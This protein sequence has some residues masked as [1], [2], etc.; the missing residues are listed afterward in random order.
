MSFGILYGL[1]WLTA[2]IAAEGPLVLIIDD[3]HWCDRASLRFITYLERRLEGLQVLVATATRNGRARAEAR[4]IGE[5]AQDPAAVSI[6]PDALTQE[7]VDTLVRERLGGTAERASRRPAERRTGGNPLLLQE[8]LKTLQAEHVTPDAAHVDL[9]RDIGPRAVSQTVLLRLRGCLTIR[10][11]SLGPWRCWAPAPGCRYRHLSELDDR[12]VA[13]ATRALISAEILRSEAPLDFV[14]PLVRDSVYYELAPSE[15]ELEHERAARALAAV[16]AP[17]EQVA[18]HL[19]AVRA[20]ANRGS[21][22]CCAR[23]R[24]CDRAR[25]DRSAVSY[26]RRALDEPAPPAN[27][28][29]CCWNSGRGGAAECAGGGRAPQRGL[30]AARRPG[31]RAR[32]AEALARMLVFT[33]RHTRASPSPAR[34]SPSSRRSS[35]ISAG[36]WRRSSCTRSR[37]APRCPMRSPAVGGRAGELAAGSAPSCWHRRRLGLGDGRRLADACAE[38]ACEALADGA[39]I[40]ADPGLHDD[41]RRRGA[42]ARRP[43]RG[44]RRS[45]RRRWPRPTAS[46]RCS[47]SA[48][49]TVAGL[50]LAAAR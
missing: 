40:A 34:R 4:L 31:Q 2:N 42:R 38:L 30:R 1:F 19:L 11:R 5:I 35:P 20:A 49:S 44:A 16:G 8:L 3:L 21:W 23:P 28:P 29:S 47:P 37:S 41:R 43:R 17:P 46:A 33:D 18:A 25:R 22:R 48:A 50:D 10:S 6:R 39:L 27:G 45:G 24:G 9:I 36:R 7:G 13:D 12:R 26:L 15:R 14:H 32:A